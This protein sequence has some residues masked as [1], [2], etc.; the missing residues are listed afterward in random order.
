MTTASETPTY[1]DASAFV[2]LVVADDESEALRAFLREGERRLVA[3]AI[4]G[5]EAVRVGRATA[6]E[7]AR[8]M[9]RALESVELVDVTA[10]IRA[11]A[12]LLDPVHLRT[13]DAIHLATALE[14]GARDVLVYDRRLADAA[15]GY[16]LNPVGPGA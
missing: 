9:T 10:A 7:L 8:L 15:A 11:R 1:V 13:L 16:G 5:V 14:V 2:K 4:L 3:S 12:R 6:G